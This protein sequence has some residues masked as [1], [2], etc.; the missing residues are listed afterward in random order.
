MQFQYTMDAFQRLLQKNVVEARFIRRHEKP[1]WSTVRGA[2]LTTNW[3]L[4]NDELGFRTLNFRPPNGR[5]MGYNHRDY[6]LIVGWDLFRQEYRVFGVENSVILNFYDVSDDEGRT[7]FWL[8]FRERIMQLTNR[9]KL[10]YMG[11][12]GNRMF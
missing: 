10:I 7:K 11:F 2:F 4:L 8:F 12:I 5:G 1:Q 9:E 3:E 6:N